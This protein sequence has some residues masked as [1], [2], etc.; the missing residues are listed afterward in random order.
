MRS[1]FLFSFSLHVVIF[2]LFFFLRPGAH[3]F[4]GY[5]TVVPVELVQLKPV[6]YR[7]PEVAKVQPKIKEFKPEQKKLE[8]VTLEKKELPKEEEPP[9]EPKVKKP[10]KEE[11]KKGK[12]VVGGKSVRL[13]VDEFPFSYYLAL[14]QSRIQA[15]WEPPFRTA[16][17]VRK[18]VI[19]FKVHRSGQIA[20][21]VIESSSGER[22]F[23][24]AAIRAVTLANPLP[25][26]PVDF[27]LRSLGVHFEFEQGI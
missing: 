12:S 6:S 2:V 27:P 22:L 8:S 3:K 4:E 17:V 5:P 18:A 15:N 26:L 10:P 25:S 9:P 11:P 23:D 13:D 14:L 20:N 19:Y 1:N 24:Q 7:A 21:I 16:A